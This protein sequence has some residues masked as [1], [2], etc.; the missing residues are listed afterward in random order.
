MRREQ[1]ESVE[2][3]TWESNEEDVQ[4][5]S[6]EK[7]PLMKAPNNLFSLMGSLFIS[8]FLSGVFTSAPKCRGSFDMLSLRCVYECEKHM[9]LRHASK[10]SR[11]KILVFQHTQN[12]F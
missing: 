11:R 12:K 3:K 4:M 9:I 6:V 7:V 10:M 2:N 5:S 8:P 1:T